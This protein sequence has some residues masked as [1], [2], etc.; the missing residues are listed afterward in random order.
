M[1]SL[2]AILSAVAA[3]RAD[4]A[5]RLAKTVQDYGNSLA[6]FRCT[7][8][9]DLMKQV[10]VA[11]AVCIHANNGIGTFLVLGMDGRMN[12][13]RISE[14]AL[15]APGVEQKTLRASLLSIDPELDI[16][17]VRASESYPWQA[18]PFA[19]SSKLAVGQEV[20]SIGLTPGDP[21]N[22][23]CVAAGYVSAIVRNPR[24]LVMVAGGQLTQPGSPVFGPD[25]RAIGLVGQQLFQGYQMVLNESTANVA[26]KSQQQGQCFLPVEEFSH[27]FQ[28]LGKKRRLAWMGAVRF[29]GVG[30][31]LAEALNLRRPGI[32]I[33]QVVPGHAADKAGL[34]NRDVIVEVD[35]QGVEKLASPELVVQNFMISLFRR[36]PGESVTLTI[37]RG[38]A[39]Q[40][41]PVT[42]ESMPA[43]AHEAARYVS[44]DLGFVVRERVLLDKYAAQ[45]PADVEGLIVAIVG[46]NTPAA[47]GG[48]QGN[49]VITNVNAQAV[50][51]A[52]AFRRIVEDALKSDRSKAINL[53]VRRGT[54]NL[55]IAI[56]PPAK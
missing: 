43:G 17:F 7:F 19:T 2:L 49:D 34:K 26:L 46:R 52:D 38:G 1:I 35:G 16:A 22:T 5:Q 13:D 9:D 3:A 40:K 15:I 23:P 27:I 48:L 4:T 51:T 33:D 32:L 45:G 53:M 56:Q 47:A 10:L 20:V 25:G 55:A 39:E 12:P 6:V 37:L 11:Q 31:E 54:Q 24:R 28:H 50:T 30:A 36:N 42:L 14:A 44:P 29:T 21:A 18:V 41:I 8:E